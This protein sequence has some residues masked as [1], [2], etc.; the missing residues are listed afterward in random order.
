MIPDDIPKFKV[1]DS[2]YNI[3]PS[4][5]DLYEVV[6][7]FDYRL[8]WT[9]GIDRL[10]YEKNKVNR[11]GL[12]HQCLI[13]NKKIDQTTIKK[14]VDK[15]QL[16]Y[17]ESTNEISFT[18][19]TNVYYILEALDGNRSKLHLKVY[20]DFKPFGFIMKPL[21]KKNFKKIISANI[22]ELNLLIDSGFVLKS[23]Q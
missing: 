16:V 18:N 14:E 7:N 13:N 4:V 1:F 22:N 2:T 21:I 17:S 9:K 6:S 10:E 11:S 19:H 5:L 20:V 12:K 8:L 23:K 3:N 15:G